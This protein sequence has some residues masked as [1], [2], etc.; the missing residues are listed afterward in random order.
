MRGVRRRWLLRGRVRW[1]MA[2]L[3]G[4]C[5]ILS[6]QEAGT[7][8][9]A[10]QTYTPARFDRAIR[11]GRPVLVDVYAEWCLPCVELDRTTFRAPEVVQ[12]LA[13]LV[14][15]RVDATRDVPRDAQA[16]LDRYGIYGVP[17]VLFFDAAGQERP[18]LRVNGFVPPKAFL[19][20][21]NKLTP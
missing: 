12:R 17:T 10:W 8:S 15:L 5:V 2:I 1:W 3:S 7:A 14:T 16:L 4:A 13:A 18:D 11:E 6:T 9:V 20:R 19:D 21:L